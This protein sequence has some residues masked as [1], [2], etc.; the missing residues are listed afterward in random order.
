MNRPAARGYND[1][2]KP[3]ALRN[4]PPLPGQK[5]FCGAGNALLLSGQERF[6]RIT[7]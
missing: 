2:V 5:Y 3:D 7:M 4:Q 1:R 6:L